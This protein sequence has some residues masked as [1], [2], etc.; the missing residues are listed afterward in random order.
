MAPGT[1]CD[2]VRQPRWPTDAHR[3]WPGRMGNV[4]TPERRMHWKHKWMLVLN[5]LKSR[6]FLVKNPI[7]AHKRAWCPW[8]VSLFGLKP[9]K[10]LM[11]PDHLTPR[12]I[13]IWNL[14]LLNKQSIAQK[15]S[16]WLL[17]N[18]FSKPGGF[19]RMHSALH[20][21]YQ[22]TKRKAYPQLSDERLSEP[23]V[24]ELEERPALCGYCLHCICGEGCMR[25]LANYNGDAFLS[26]TPGQNVYLK[27]YSRLLSTAHHEV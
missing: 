3:V 25:W 13:N 20:T 5:L 27:I 7:E 16:V 22:L 23:S 21:Q 17:P 12:H 4:R 2:C 15:F 14:S 24:P 19:R 9:Q 8:F 26:A 18:P 6:Y 10:L 11:G 1:I